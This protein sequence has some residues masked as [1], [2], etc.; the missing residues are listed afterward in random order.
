MPFGGLWRSPRASAGVEAQL[1][2]STIMTTMVGGPK[3]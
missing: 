3:N 1:Y 2:K